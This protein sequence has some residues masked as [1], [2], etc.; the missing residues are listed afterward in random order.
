MKYLILSLLLLPPFFT[1]SAQNVVHNPGFELYSGCPDSWAQISHANEWSGVSVDYYNSC[2]TNPSE[3]GVPWNSSGYQ[4]AY[5]GNAYAG[6]LGAVHNGGGELLIGHTDP[7]HTFFYYRVSIRISNAEAYINASEGIQVKFYSATSNPGTPQ[8]DYLPYG[9]ITDTLWQ[10][11]VDTFYNTDQAYDR[12]QIGNNHAWVNELIVGSSYYFI[13]GVNVTPIG[14]FWTDKVQTNIRCHGEVNGT[15]S[16]VTHG[17]KPPITYLWSPGNQ[18]TSSISGLGAGTYICK[19]LDSTGYPIYDTFYITEPPVLAATMNHT[20]TCDH[21]NNGTASVTVTGGVTPYTYSW[22][23]SGG[24]AA[25][26]TGLAPGNY[27]CTVTDSNNCTTTAT[28]TITDPPALTATSTQTNVSCNAGNTGTATVTASG[29]TPSYH[30][31]WV[32]SGGTAATATGLTAGNYTCTITDDNT[33]THDVTFT[34]TEP[35]AINP[36]ATQTN[37]TCHNAANGTATVAV[38]GGVPPYTYSWAPSGGNAASATALLAGTYTCTITD[39]NNCVFPQVFT[40]TEADA[41]VAVMNVTDVSCYGKNDGKVSVTASHGA[42]GYT[43]S[44]APTV[45][46]DTIIT[47]LVP[48]SYTCTITDANNCVVTPTATVS[49]PD[50]LKVTNVTSVVCFG[51]N[52]GK[53]IANVTGGTLPYTYLWTPTG[54]TTPNLSSLAPGSY[55]CTITDAHGCIIADTVNMIETAKLTAAFIFDSSPETGNLPI[56]FYNSSSANASSISYGTLATIPLARIRDP[57]KLYND[58]GNFDVCLVAIDTNNCADTACKEVHSYVTKLAVIPSAFSPNGD[59]ENDVLYVRGYRI[60]SIHLRIYN[61]WGNIVFET[62]DK[63]KGWDG[64]YK[65]QKQYSE[66]YAYTLEATFTDGS[67]QEKQGSV[68]LLQ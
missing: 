59:G 34:I 13:D 65:G 68:I 62:K 20:N 55:I 1:V 30:Y 51:R 8:I 46:T 28:V 67:T 26:A 9:L 16:V 6:I 60:Q 21:A 31:A 44:W 33:C 39:A 11:L 38:T 57:K 25:T 10:E 37:V 5:D 18:T 58:S 49:Q 15:A 14:P 4:V 17:G 23:P 22:T 47:G 19:I 43:Y 52:D 41:L 45:G 54:A 35:P 56:S 29:G 27:T 63:D 42:P 66:A 48:G 32:P 61:R 64:T 3:C 7:L 24:T 12:I 36:N 2:T 40:I 50:S 53:E